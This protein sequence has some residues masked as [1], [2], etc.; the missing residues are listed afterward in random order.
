MFTNKLTAQ[1]EG[2]C[3]HPCDYNTKITEAQL[4][5]SCGDSATCRFDACATGNLTIANI[6]RD[7]EHEFEN[8]TNLFGMH[9]KPVFVMIVLMT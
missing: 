2:W 4:R 3:G 9:R 5:A 6:T 1:G 7:I 8:K